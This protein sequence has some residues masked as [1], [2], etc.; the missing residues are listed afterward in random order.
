MKLQVPIPNEAFVWKFDILQL[1]QRRQQVK[2]EGGGFGRVRSMG[3]LDGRPWFVEATKARIVLL[4][5][6]SLSHFSKPMTML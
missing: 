1:L 5:I 6:F 3:E 4:T 2:Y